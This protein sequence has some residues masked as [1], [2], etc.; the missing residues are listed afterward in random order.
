MSQTI[1]SALRHNFL[2]YSSQ[3]DGKTDRKTDEGNSKVIQNDWNVDRNV[4]CPGHSL[5]FGDRA[6]L[7]NAGAVV[8]RAFYNLILA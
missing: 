1:L 3:T 2:I 4:L 7:K 8:K 5:V 6:Q